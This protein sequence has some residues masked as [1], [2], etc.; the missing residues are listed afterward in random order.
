[1]R[2]PPW[3]AL[4]LGPRPAGQERGTGAGQLKEPESSVQVDG[5]V[6]IQVLGRE[7]RLSR[8]SPARFVSP[9]ACRRSRA[10][11]GSP[12]RSGLG[13][14]PV[15]GCARERWTKSAS[16]RGLAS[17]KH[18]SSGKPSQPHGPEGASPGPKEGGCGPQPEE[19]RAGGQTPSSPQKK[20]KAW[21]PPGLSPWRGWGPHPLPLAP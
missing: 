3:A 13:A 18:K 9:R 16:K 8:L 5:G 21:R 2:Q 4:A 20:S 12:V 14:G 19:G 1:M 15:L 17:G 6:R 11:L 7:A 10:A